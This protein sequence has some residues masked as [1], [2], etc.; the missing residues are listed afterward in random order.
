MNVRNTQ[1]WMFSPSHV[2]RGFPWA[3][4]TM[5]SPPVNGGC[6]SDHYGRRRRDY[7]CGRHNYGSGSDN[8]R[9]RSNDNR[10]RIYYIAHDCGRSDC[11]RRDSPSTVMVTMSMSVEVMPWHIVARAA[12]MTRAA[13]MTTRAWTGKYKSGHCNGHKH[14]CQFLVHVFLLFLSLLTTL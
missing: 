1:D 6:R 4:R 10:R 13:V 3:S 12:M 8:C 5:R 2:F 7:R 11:R 14:Y 9:R